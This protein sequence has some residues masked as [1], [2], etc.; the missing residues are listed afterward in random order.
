MPDIQEP[1]S[2]ISQ[3]VID[4]FKKQYGDK[5]ICIA[6][7]FKGDQRINV[8]LTVVILKPD[9]RVRTEYM[10]WAEKNPNKAEGILIN[11]CVLT[12]KD[13]VKADE[14]LFIAAIDA[15]A[16]LFPTGNA[17]IKNA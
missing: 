9:S 14:E 8:S 16:Q 7:L 4:G 13:E 2:P 12:S 5:R 1:A 10:K 3:D 6:E 11:S 15:I 17:N